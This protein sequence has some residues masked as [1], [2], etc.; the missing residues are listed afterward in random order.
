MM[1]NVTRVAAVF[2]T[3]GV[4]GGMVWAQGRGFGGG[5]RGGDQRID[6][7]YFL[8][9]RTHQFPIRGTSRDFHQPQPRID[10]IRIKGGKFFD[11]LLLLFY[12]P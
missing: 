7:Q 1:N 3:L 5:G 11:H 2:L 12:L 9:L 10:L 4:I 8:S 6:C